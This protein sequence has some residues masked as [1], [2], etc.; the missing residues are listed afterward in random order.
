MAKGSTQERSQREIRDSNGREFAN[1]V[2]QKEYIVNHF[3][4]SFRKDPNEPDNLEN[5]IENFLGPVVL[6][7]PLVQSLKLNQDECQNLESEITI[8]ELD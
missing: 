4:E 6:N 1:E 3:A 2:Q 5:C 8:E 7:H